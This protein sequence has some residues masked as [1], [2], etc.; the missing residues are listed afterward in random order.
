MGPSRPMSNISREDFL[1][2]SD[3]FSVKEFSLTFLPSSGRIPI[4]AII[5]RVTAGARA[6]ARP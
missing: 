3:E 1:K 4:L 6:N 5:F 2:S